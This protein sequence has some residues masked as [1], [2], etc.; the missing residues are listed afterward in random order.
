MADILVIAS[1][2]SA[3]FWGGTGRYVRALT[4]HSLP[5]WRVT[6]VSIP[7]YALQVR[8]GAPV[9]QGLRRV[10]DCEWE[11]IDNEFCTLLSSESFDIDHYMDLSRRIAERIQPCLAAHYDVLY[12]QDFYNTGLVSALYHRISIDH[13]SAAAHLPL[14]ARFSY[15]DKSTDEEHQQALEAALLRLADSIVVP[16]HFTKRNLDLVYN[17]WH[18]KVHVVALGVDHTDRKRPRTRD[19][20]TL[21][22]VMRFTDQKGLAAFPEIIKAMKRKRIT[23]NWIVIGSGPREKF[24]FETFREALRDGRLKHFAFVEPGDIFDLYRNL[25]IYISTSAYE[26]F[27]LAVLEAMSVGCPTVAFDVC[28]LRELITNDQEGYLVSPNDYPALVEMIIKLTSDPALYARISHNA[29]ERAS[30]YSWPSHM[31]A[32]NRRVWGLK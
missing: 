31:Q 6:V 13:L 3:R 20:I 27:G 17:V 23:A 24:F 22:S 28:G 16:S 12:V 9:Q 10:S 15:F 25:D 19:E 18:K 11:Y 4:T 29:C 30:L 21:G 2:C 1:E 14:S 7:S 5:S 26:T 32:L 8:G